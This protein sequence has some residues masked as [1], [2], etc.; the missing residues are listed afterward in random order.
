[1]LVPLFGLSSFR[2]LPQ[3]VQSF[4][5]AKATGAAGPAAP[6]SRKTSRFP[7]RQA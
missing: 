2:R 5:S 7:A 4:K 1:M 6:F 3:A